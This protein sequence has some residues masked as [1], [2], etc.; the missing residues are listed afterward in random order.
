M[1]ILLTLLTLLQVFFEDNL[2]E[3]QEFLGLSVYSASKPVGR[4]LSVPAGRLAVAAR[5]PCRAGRT[6][7][8]RRGG[9]RVALKSLLT[10]FYS[11]NV[12]ESVQMPLVTFPYP[13]REWHARVLSP[14]PPPRSIVPGRVTL[15]WH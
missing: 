11:P 10:H 14:P 6:A 1:L 15:S 13:G 7:D 2:K 5:A 8:S 3:I 4:D 9:T 12:K